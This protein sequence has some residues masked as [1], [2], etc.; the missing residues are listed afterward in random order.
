[1]YPLSRWLT[2]VAAGASML[3]L[4]SCATM[5]V[6]SYVARGVD[7]TGYRT[8][9]WGPADTVSTGDPR[10]DNNP[11]FHERVYA[12]VEEKLATRR[13]EKTT[14][15]TPDLLVHFHPSMTQRIEAGAL[16]REYEY[17][18]VG[19]CRPYVYESGTLVL[20]FVDPRTNKVIWR[21]WAERS[22]DGVVDN[23][24]WMEESIDEAVA[25]I[26]DKLPPGL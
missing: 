6:S 25:R 10:L 1:M 20:D 8:Y 5:N 13:F 26:L 15:G 22:M 12:A 18:S 16:D 11:F 7:F 17:C 3:A 19:D 4:T 14:S 23:Q 24:E 2:L 9:A 21:G